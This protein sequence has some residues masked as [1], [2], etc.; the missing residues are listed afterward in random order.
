[1]F[2][3]ILYIVLLLFESMVEIE[4]EIE[5]R[6]QCTEIYDDRIIQAFIYLSMYLS[7]PGMPTQQI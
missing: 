2:V 1:M 4:I 6:L 3:C 7:I 5:S